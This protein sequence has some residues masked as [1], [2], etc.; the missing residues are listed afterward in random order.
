M[1]STSAQNVTRGISEP[2]N[3]LR[4]KNGKGHLMHKA[5]KDVSQLFTEIKKA[6]LCTPLYTP[7]KVK[8]LYYLVSKL[9]SFVTNS[10][11]YLGRLN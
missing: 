11:T 8:Q 10:T 2:R 3:G 4:T 5:K 1:W 6:Y 9:Y 7:I